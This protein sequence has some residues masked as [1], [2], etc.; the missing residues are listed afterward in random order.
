MPVDLYGFIDETVR[1]AL[2][3]VAFDPERDAVDAVQE[4]VYKTEHLRRLFEDA[5]FEIISLR[6]ALKSLSIVAAHA[7]SLLQRDF[8]RRPSRFASM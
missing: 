2:T 5:D 1:A 4:A 7:T 8:P 3:K 6:A